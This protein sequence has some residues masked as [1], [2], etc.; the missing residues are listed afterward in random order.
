MSA[1]DDPEAQAEDV[2]SRLGLGANDP[3]N[4]LLDSVEDGLGIAVSVLDLG[5]EVA[6]AYLV[7]RDTPFIL[8]NGNDFKYR[9]R[10]TLAHELGHHEL[11]HAAVADPTGNIGG[12]SSEDPREREANL[13][14]G[15]LLAPASGVHALVESMGHPPMTVNVA[16]HVAHEFGI[17]IPAAFVRLSQ[18]GLVTP[19]ARD[20]IQAALD[21]GD[22]RGVPERL[23]IRPFEDSLTRLGSE[24]LPRLPAA[25]H[26]NALSAYR[27]GLIDKDRLAEVL[28]RSR[29]QLDKHLAVLGIGID[30]S[31]EEP[32]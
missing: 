16:A 6:G 3:V 12:T 29:D 17:S 5:K 32:W 25:L 4:D 7:R 20:R 28:G 30:E 2:R 13:F 9:R 22:H 21:R 31:E 10:F 11:G 14:A 15:E 27:D 8:I 19:E 18:A 24:S 23:G 26:Q 1:A